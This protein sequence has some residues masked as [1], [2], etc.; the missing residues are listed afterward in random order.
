MKGS[1]NCLPQKVV[2]S[3]FF[4]AFVYYFSNVVKAFYGTLSKSFSS[5]LFIPNIYKKWFS[6]SEFESAK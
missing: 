6:L 2:S 5:Y 4:Q 1:Y 3:L